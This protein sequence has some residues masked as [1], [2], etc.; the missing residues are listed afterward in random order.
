MKRYPGIRQIDDETYEINFRPRKGADRVFKR[1]KAQSVK[2]ASIKMAELITE[3]RKIVGPEILEQREN[4]TFD[5]IFLAFERNLISDNLAKK[6]LYGLKKVYR[7][8]FTEYRLKKYPQIKT[9]AQ[10]SLPFFLE[11]K[12][13]YGVELKRPRGLRTELGRVVNIMHRLRRLRYCSEG[14][15]KDLRE[16][17]IPERTKKNYPEITDSNIKSLLTRAKSERLDLYGP[18]YFMKRTGRRVEETTLI[19]REDVIWEGISPRRINIRAETTKMKRVAPLN[20]LD[21]D[22]EAHI[23]QAYQRSKNF[24]SPYL[25]VNKYGKKCAQGVISKYLGALSEEMFGVRITSHYFRHRFCT[26]C[27]KANLPLVDVMAISGIKD[28]GI[29]TKY[30]SHNTNEGLA[31]VLESSRLV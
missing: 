2:E 17:K 27:G 9:P 19:E 6:T 5:E 21:S 29:L 1:V 30:Y 4:L 7:R 10:L 3:A 8:M 28:V 26:E 14:I 16:M 25:F 13:Y 15:V 23:R 31:K 12:G 20:Y 11:Y 18:I 22:L 24:R